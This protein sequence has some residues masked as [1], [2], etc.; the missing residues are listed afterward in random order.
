M[1]IVT[2]VIDN[3]FELDILK[4]INFEVVALESSVP[5]LIWGNEIETIY[6]SSIFPIHI[7]IS[8]KIA[9]AYLQWKC[10]V[11]EYKLLCAC[12]SINAHK[13]GGGAGGLY[14]LFVY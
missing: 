2:V 9:L 14:K 7:V 11:M 1:Q 5:I 6:I 8:V 12:I 3:C 10:M 4:H 13:N